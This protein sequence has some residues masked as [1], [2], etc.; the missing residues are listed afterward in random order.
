MSELK[1]TIFTY[2]TNNIQNLEVFEKFTTVI[3]IALEKINNR[4]SFPFNICCRQRLLSWVFG[5]ICLIYNRL[6]KI[7][8]YFEVEGLFSFNNRFLVNSFL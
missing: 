4:S 7:A 2:N 5:Y 3:F 1:V 6:H 8:P